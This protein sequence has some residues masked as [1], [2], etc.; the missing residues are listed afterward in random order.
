MIKEGG[1]LKID[2]L[3]GLLTI[4]ANTDKITV[5]ELATRFEV[6]RR[7]IFRDLDTLN[8]AGIPIVS[9]PGIGGGVAV[10]EG[11]KLKNQILSTNDIKEIFTALNGLKSIDN[12]SSISNLIAKLV[13]ENKTVIFSQSDYVIDLSSWFK[14]SI[15]NQKI[16]KLHQA[17][18][19]HKCVRLEYVSKNSRLVRVVEPHKLVFKLSYWYIYAFCKEKN[20]FRLFKLNRIVSLEI[21]NEQFQ[22]HSITDIKFDE[23]YGENLF[24]TECMPGSVEVI[25]EYDISNEYAL[26]NKI[27]ALF[28]EKDIAPESNT[29][30]I[31]FY[32]T[33]LSWISD[34][35]LGIVDKVRV[36]SPPELYYEVQ[37]RL[38][39]INTS[40]EG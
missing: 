32:T 10:I 25:L 18:D 37:L 33:D 17:I 16:K 20:G 31:H 11:Y 6:S 26:T 24:S 19:Q 39:N 21:L 34:F 28:F 29:A 7:T 40:Y 14:D 13:P 9:Y 5:Q 4:L 36:V 38:K 35:I 1:I 27:D 23:N 3:L 15:I 8:R 30:K 12:N 22:L 2:R